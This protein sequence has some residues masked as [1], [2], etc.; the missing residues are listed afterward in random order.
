MR[1]RK[2]L[3]LAVLLALPTALRAQEIQE[4]VSLGIERGVEIYWSV[5]TAPEDSW[6][7]LAGRFLSGAA[8][9]PRLQ[10]VNRGG[11]VPASL[12]KVPYTM[13]R[14]DEQRLTALTLFPLDRNEGEDW[15]HVVGQA[16][17]LH[18]ESLTGIALWFSGDAGR[19]PELAR[20]N[21]LSA[22][23]L[24]PGQEVRIPARMLS[25]AFLSPAAFDA[26]MREQALHPPRPLAP[27]APNSASAAMKSSA[28]A[29]TPIAIPPTTL[30]TTVS[31]AA[32]TPPLGGFRHSAPAAVP[33]GPPAAG[34]ATLPAPMQSQPGGELG[35]ARDGKTEYAIYHLKPGEALYSAVVIRFFGLLDA[36]EVNNRALALAR[37]NGIANVTKIP[38]G[39]ALRLPANELLP[40]YAPPGSVARLK[41]EGRQRELQQ[42]A[43]A[44]DLPQPNPALNISAPDVPNPSAPNSVPSVRAGKLKG[45]TVILDAGHGG[46]DPGASGNGVWESDFV[47]DIYVRTR[48]ALAAAGATVAM[49]VRDPSAGYLPRALI[50]T[51][52]GRLEILATPPFIPA[53]GNTRGAVNARA[54]LIALLARGCRSPTI[55]TSFHADAL[56][57]SVRGTMVYIPDAELSAPRAER[58]AAGKRGHG[59]DLHR[60]GSPGAITR[61]ER[62]RAEAWSGR[63]AT[64]LVRALR[65][66]KV[67]VH[68]F[69]PVRSF[70][71]R[72]GHPWVPAVLRDAP[73]TFKM[74]VEVCN[75]AN[76]EDAKNL[77]DPAF[78]QRIA[79]AYVEALIRQFAPEKPKGKK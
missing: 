58:A 71:V 15:M 70:V 26:W 27:S 14:P 28:T 76:P 39:F 68:P 56:H 13:L 36:R 53:R 77:Q 18:M 37:E 7:S 34:V 61:A 4:G 55:F 35:F 72:E 10:A 3:P 11:S 49:V 31:S 9:G 43:A 8:D 69:D 25:P 54:Q 52:T 59:H 23:G 24:A 33:V 29:S 47:Y 19:Y 63:L 78:R 5:A 2:F 65:D 79:D 67:E 62:V 66:G 75:L 30:P 48:A 20:A 40:Q 1:F 42:A 12:I 32:S 57:P 64:G 16:E 22:A 6:E 17:K 50:S 46:P 51:R 73:L 21:A 45:V 38:A 44:L 41:F 74:L 60:A